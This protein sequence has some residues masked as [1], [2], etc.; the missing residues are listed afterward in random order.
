MTELASVYLSIKDRIKKYK[1][2]GLTDK[3]TEI[4]LRLDIENV[5]DLIFKEMGL[6]L[7]KN[8]KD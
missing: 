5:I 6:T 4:E 8:S 2:K 3:Q 1:T 7:E